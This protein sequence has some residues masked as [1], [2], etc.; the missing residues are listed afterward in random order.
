M[1]EKII[2]D[3]IAVILIFGY[4][5]YFAYLCRKKALKKNRDHLTWTVLGLLFGLIAHIVL[6]LSSDLKQPPSIDVKRINRLSITGII[7]SLMYLIYSVIGII[8][9]ML[10]RTYADIETNFVFLI[11]GIIFIVVSV[12][13]KQQQKWGWFGYILLLT[14]VI[15]QSFRS[16]DLY[17][18]V[19][20][21]G[22]LIT[23]IG[24]T[25]SSVRK[26]YFPG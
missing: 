26:L 19:L 15:L 6:S 2:F 17:M 4:D 12:A 24:A 10:D 23:I 22:A 3:V 8:L 7:L 9:S 13:F 5:I 18:F 25:S 20:A 1:A 21:F 16:M 14:L 11:I